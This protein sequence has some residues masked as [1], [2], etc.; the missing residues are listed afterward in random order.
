[1]WTAGGSTK[2][3]MISSRK[4]SS[5]FSTAGQRANHAERILKDLHEDQKLNDLN[6]CNLVLTAVKDSM[7]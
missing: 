2:T 7:R 1:M 3:S 5:A 4:S 6:S